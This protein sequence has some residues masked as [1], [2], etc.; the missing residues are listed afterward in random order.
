[1]EHTQDL[2]FFHSSGLACAF[3][4]DLV[5]EVVPMATLSSPPGMPST[6]AG[7]LNLRGTAI[8]ILRL[9]RLFHLPEQPCG[10]HTPLIILR[11]A[12]KPFGILAGAVRQIA[13]TATASL[14]PLPEGQVFHDCAAATVEAGGEIFC[15]LSPERILLESEQRLVAEFQALAQE[16]LLHL[17]VGT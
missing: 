2:L 17:E 5:R 7:F 6:L 14:L 15:L 4:L 8:P 3:R 10:L 13:R 12:E 1:M 11:G 16:R 9:D